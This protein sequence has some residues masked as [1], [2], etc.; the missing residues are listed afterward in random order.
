M[1]LRLSGSMTA[2][3]HVLMRQVAFQPGTS[4][5]Q[6]KQAARATLE[7]EGKSATSAEI[8]KRT[9]VCS[10]NAAKTYVSTWVQLGEFARA[11]CGVRKFSDLTAEHIEKYIEYKIDKG[12][13]KASLEREL[14]A[15]GK[16]AVTLEKATDGRSFEIVRQGVANM[17]D[18]VGECAERR[19]FDRAYA[20]PRGIVEALPAGHI[21]LA[22][23]FIQESGCRI[24]EGC[25]LE[26]AQLKGLGIDQHTGRECGRIEVVGKGGNR[27]IISVS[28]RLY[29]EIRNEL[30]AN[31]RLEVNQNHL[32]AAV[33][34][35]A[36]PEYDQRGIH[37]LR[38][39]YAQGRV[40][41]LQ[42]HGVS[43]DVSKAIVSE[44]M[45]HHRV[46]ITEV[47]LASK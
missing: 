27:Y 16:L 14:S 2:Q 6:E 10:D 25:R 34:A 46:A 1:A 7:A 21:G 31:G 18:D 22:G 5:S 37:G 12:N 45:G 41:D 44:E 20:D 23:R 40:R 15:I 47:Y 32:R 29:G 42:A 36:G 8:A 43:R 24:A 9:C 19:L 28:P 4:R 11:E 39:N 13:D 3:A 35:I 33:R 26:P 38:Y 17:R 30:A